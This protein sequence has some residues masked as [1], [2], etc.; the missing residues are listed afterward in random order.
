LKVCLSSTSN[1]LDAQLDPKL[2]RCAYLLIVDAETL[3]FEAIP[4]TA[5]DANSG[6]GIQVAQ[7]I[8]NKGAKL[9]LTGNVGP[10]A[11][12][13]L[14]ATGIDVLTASG[15]VREVLEAFK[16]GE[17]KKVGAPTVSGHS[18]VQKRQERS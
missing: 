17:L 13:A 7:T 11:F 9:V 15:T 14:S 10:N 5:V 6:A 4:N 3:N 16:R 18:G 8:A 2:G 1:N 12:K